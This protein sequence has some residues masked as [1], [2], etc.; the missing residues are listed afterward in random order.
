MPQCATN[1]SSSP[2]I[3]QNPIRHHRQRHSRFNVIVLAATTK[4]LDH[5]GITPQKRTASRVTAHYFRPPSRH[6]VT[7]Q[8]EPRPVFQITVGGTEVTPRLE[9]S[10]S[11]A[12]SRRKLWPTSGGAVDQIRRLIC[13]FGLFIGPEY[14]KN[15][16]CGNHAFFAR[17]IVYY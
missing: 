3:T 16:R 10:H 2:L 4:R 15:F 7:G 13:R 12:P 1:A 8:D 11:R 6:G 17:S 9:G 14:S 5:A